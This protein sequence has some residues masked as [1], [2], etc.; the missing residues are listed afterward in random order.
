ML[1]PTVDF[2][3]F[4]ALVFLGHWLLNPKPLPW[5]LFMIAASYV[6]YA[7]WD[8]AFV[9]LLVGFSAIAQLGALA[10]HR[11]REPSRRR[12]ALGISIAAALAPLAWF[13]YYGFFSLNVANAF[14][15]VGLGAPLPLLQIVLPIGVSFYT[16]MGISYIFDVY[17]DRLEPA[18]WLDTFLF[19]SFFPHLV[20]G[21]IVRGSELLPQFRTA[22]DPR[23]G[24]TVLCP[25]LRGAA[26]GSLSKASTPRPTPA[27]RSPRGNSRR[28]RGGRSC[29]RSLE[30]IPRKASAR[31]S[32]P[33]R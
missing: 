21:P 23:G 17:R 29:A 13:K 22:K 9:W 8:P 33:Q 5:K 26:R 15:T 27:A 19:L 3:V 28:T 25:V 7:W 10:V 14:D 12:L 1:F 4:F 30:A 20:A 6:F 24:A 16:F 11:I 18:G 2:A 31:R 32:V